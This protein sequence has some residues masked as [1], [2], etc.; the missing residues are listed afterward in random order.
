[1]KKSIRKSSKRGEIILSPNLPITGDCVGDIRA[2]IEKARK[3]VVRHVNSTMTLAYWLI[4]RRIVVEEQ[5]GK[6]RAEYGWHLMERIS[7]ELTD[8]YCRGF[9]VANL[10]NFREFYLQNP[11]EKAIRYALRSELGWTHHRA[12]IRVADPKARSYYLDEAVAQGWS[13]RDLE[14]EIRMRTYE[15]VIGNHGVNVERAIVGG[16]APRPEA[17]LR[18]P[19]VAEFLNLP[20][21]LRGKERKVEKRIID[22][23]EK[24]LLELG[25]GFALVGRQF[26]VPIGGEEKRID[27]VFY[28][29]ILRCYVLVDLKTSKLTSRDIGQIDAYRRIFDA[30]KKSET[31]QPTIGILLGTEIRE[32]D[33]RY[34]VMA[35]C[36]RLFATKLMP[37]LPS[38]GELI[39][40]I[41]R[42]RG[43]T[44]ARKSAVK[45]KEGK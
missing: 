27:L 30:L 22:N 19:C 10:R 17:I 15:R 34:S 7:R 36:E 31:D 37:Y 16:D 41:E 12:I 11:S 25:R 44:V 21:N 42:S 2:I 43:R 13:T 40:E 3:G 35:D 5:G 28:N 33:V 8:V 14:R 1:M 26:R 38:K 6:D 23:L 45:T 29:I 9:G 32:E 24:F 39:D 18:D 4:G 20:G